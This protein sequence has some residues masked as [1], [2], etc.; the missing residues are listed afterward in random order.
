M[1]I[2]LLL[3]IFHFISINSNIFIL[4]YISKV[5]IFEV[6]FTSLSFYLVPF[7]VYIY[8]AKLITVDIVVWHQAMPSANIA[9]Y[10]YYDNSFFIKSTPR[11]LAWLH[12]NSLNFYYGYGLIF[13]FWQNTLK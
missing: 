9:N 4:H 2:G 10:R 3:I 7:K 5:Y 12:P 6:P 1:N 13:S 11:T 8:V